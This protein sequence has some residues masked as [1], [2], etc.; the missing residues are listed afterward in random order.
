[1]VEPQSSHPLTHTPA[2]GASGRTA[3]PLVEVARANRQG[4]RDLLLGLVT[5]ALILSVLAILG[6]VGEPLNFVLAGVALAIF[7]GGWLVM[8]H[9]GR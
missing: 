9:G 3:S 1:M 2:V 5:L 4:L 8:R 7:G 6:R